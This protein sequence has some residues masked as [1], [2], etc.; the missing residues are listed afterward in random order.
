MSDS[1]KH[2]KKIIKESFDGVQRK[3]PTDLWANISQVTN[4]TEDEFSIH[5]SFNNQT[6]TAPSETWSRVKK[7][8]IIDEVWDRIVAYEDRRKRKIIWWYIGSFSILLLF[9]LLM[10]NINSN[11]KISEFR[12]N[13]NS[14]E[15][16]KIIDPL[17]QEN[18][19]ISR[20]GNNTISKQG[21]NTIS[22]IDRNG[23]FLKN[24]GTNLISSK[25]VKTNN[26]YSQAVNS[27]ISSEN[28]MIHSNT[29]NDSSNIEYF[30][31]D[32]IPL[33]KIQ[34]LEFKRFLDISTLTFDSVHN[35]KIKR[36]E[37]GLI[38]SFGN[39]WLF[40]N[41][42]KEGLKRKSLISNNLSTG[43]SIGGVIVYNFSKKS[44]LELGYDFY[45]VHKQA[46]DFYDEGHLF[47]KNIN[48]TQQKVYL[49]YKFRF[50]AITVK[51]NFVFKTGFF[52]S[53][54]IKEQATID[55]V[56]NEV[57][58]SFEAFDYGLNIGAGIE[59]NLSK[60]K[61]EYGVKTNIG[62]HNLTANTTNFPKKFDYATTYILGG[63]VSI[64]YLF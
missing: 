24:S 13:K 53:H 29:N 61:V 57:I 49:S 35:P 60:F 14:V 5:N 50:N 44:G 11:K 18:N 36:F 25:I 45:S 10:L 33:K 17:N 59:H 38:A 6:K 28:Q 21:N 56:K 30:S 4:L 52:Y 40:N 31:I 51:R 3:A 26:N 34:L 43:Y 39:S 2:I 15:N 16:S 19:T 58:S 32:R 23:L 7:Q 37:V 62:L 63:Y 20:Q 46:Y 8:L 1:D 55:G 47:H 22:K 42:V 48:L 41:D 27:V 12:K 64:R 54:S 9:S